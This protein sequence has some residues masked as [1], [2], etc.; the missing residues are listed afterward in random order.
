MIKYLILVNLLNALDGLVTLLAVGQYG[1][2]IEANIHLH[3][4]ILASVLLI[5]I[6][7]LI[8]ISWITWEYDKLTKHEKQ[9]FINPVLLGLTLL[10]IGV[11][12]WN[13][14]VLLGKL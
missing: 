4:N 8:G 5:K 6:P 13:F 1:I 14:S 9:K 11:L 3:N 10:F 7:V 2:S 12:M